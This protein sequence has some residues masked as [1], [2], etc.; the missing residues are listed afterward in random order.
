MVSR[1]RSS[2]ERALEGSRC[3]DSAGTRLI[4]STCPVACA[5]FDVSELAEGG[6]VMLSPSDLRSTL[7]TV[8]ANTWSWWARALQSWCRGWGK[9]EQIGIATRERGARID[10]AP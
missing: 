1:L 2:C 9:L 5:S 3:S 7:A 4:A 10:G 6:S 8:S